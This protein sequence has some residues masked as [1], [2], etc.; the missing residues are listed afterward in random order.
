MS[1]QATSPKS[2]PVEI[3]VDGKPREFDIFDPNLPDWVEEGSFSSDSYPY[4]KKLKRS[5]YEEE[6]EL[7]QIELVKLQ[8]WQEKSGERII[9]IFE[10]RDAAGKGGTIKAFRENMNPRRA[11]VVALPKPTERERGEWYYQRYI[12]HFPTSGEIVM[13]DRS[14]YNRAG[15]EPVMGFCTPEQTAHFLAETPRFESGLIR[16]GIRLHKFWLNVGQ[17]MQL[18]R[19]HDRAHSKLKFWKLSPM[20]IKA[21][22]L[23]EEYTAAR[24]AMLEATDTDDAPWTVLRTNDK[25]RGRLNAIKTLLSTIEYDHRDDKLVSDI[26]QRIVGRGGRI[27]KGI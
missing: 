12:S 18:K 4:D 3:M 19:F 26:D 23:W 21:L 10:G 15:V 24:D 5:E 7:L 1:D 27:L 20:D 13:F 16:D 6:L 8:Q 22:T 14:W 2:A 9:S 25:R 11:R 17:E